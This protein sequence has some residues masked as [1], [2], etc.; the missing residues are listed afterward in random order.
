MPA[1]IT[2]QHNSRAYNC[3]HAGL[4]GIYSASFDTLYTTPKPDFRDTSFCGVV[5][6]SSD[7]ALI[8][9]DRSVLENYHASAAF[10]LMKE[11]E[12]D[13]LAGLNKEDYR[14]FGS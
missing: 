6:F 1:F 5:L 7:F 4:A 12:T 9:N 13:I 2:V 8:Y 3:I 14:S 10:R 11:A